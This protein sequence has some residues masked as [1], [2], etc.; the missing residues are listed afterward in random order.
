M[1][2][3]RDPL[4]SLLRIGELSRARREATGAVSFQLPE[5]RILI[6]EN[7]SVAIRPLATAK[8]RSVV[9]ETMIMTGEAVA[10]WARGHKIPIPYSVQDGSDTEK[11]PGTLA[12][13]WSLRRS[14]KRSKRSSVP[15]PHRGL[16][17]AAYAQVTSPLRRYFDLMVHQ[18][19]NAVLRGDQ[20]MDA[21]EIVR[22]VGEVEALLPSL[23][24]AELHSEKH[25]T[26]VYLMQNPNWKGKGTVVDHR[27]R[28]LM[29]LIPSLGL[30]TSI[31]T[32][33]DYPHD[34]EITVKVQDV[35][36]PTLEARFRIA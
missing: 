21:D 24:R 32:K 26:M 27:D 3:D 13:M 34:S 16:G 20:P 33:R 9:Q 22:R 30:E 19:L 35:E 15:G 14:L 29:V 18:Q 31:L 23:R 17:L 36:L 11:K 12:E 2:I 25:W 8:S 4:R 6:S 5:V 28:R 7:G 10:R 1:L